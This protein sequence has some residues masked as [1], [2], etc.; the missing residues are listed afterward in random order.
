MQTTIKFSA[1]SGYGK[2]GMSYSYS[3]ADI[4]EPGQFLT[5]LRTWIQ[6]YLN[7][8]NE[9]PDWGQL[10]HDWQTNIEDRTTEEAAI[11]A[12]E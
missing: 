6:E 7:K 8:Q 9:E 5:E 10:G 12:A 11:V 2:D 1:K 3:S 4:Y